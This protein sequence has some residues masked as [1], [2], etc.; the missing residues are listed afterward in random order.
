MGIDTVGTIVSV[1]GLVH[2]FIIDERDG[3]AMNYISSFSHANLTVEGD[4]DVNEM[5]TA[6]AGG[7][8]EPRPR[9]RPVMNDKRSKQMGIGLRETLTWMLDGQELRRP[10]AK[11]FKYNQ[12]GMVYME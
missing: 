12:Y 5:L 10:A 3:E 6:T 4:H 8:N 7:N 9:G 11:G 1:A 2:N